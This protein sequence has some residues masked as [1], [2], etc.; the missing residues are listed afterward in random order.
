[1]STCAAYDG[2]RTKGKDFCRRCGRRRGIHRRGLAVLA[3]GKDQKG[4]ATMAATSEAMEVASE[5]H[6]LAAEALA[7]ALQM[8]NPGAIVYVTVSDGAKWEALKQLAG[9]G[10]KVRRFGDYNVMCEA[11]E[12]EIG[13]MTLH[14]SGPPWKPSIAEVHAMF[15]A[16][17]RE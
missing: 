7:K 17:G 1:M 6:R 16:K 11:L 13:D 9:A 5:R 2:P 14:A 10:V 12:A 15:F 4:R 3:G 8:G